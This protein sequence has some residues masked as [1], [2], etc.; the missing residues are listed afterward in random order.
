MYSVVFDSLRHHGLYHQVL[1]SKKFSRQEYWNR[2]PFPIPG[3]LHDPEI[4]PA[5]LATPVLAGGSF[6]TD[7]PGKPWYILKPAQKLALLI[8][9]DVPVLGN[10]LMPGTTLGPSTRISSFNTHSTP[11]FNRVYCSVFTRMKLGLEVDKRLAKITQ[12]GNYRG[13]I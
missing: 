1:L 8:Q 11:L 2:L 10:Q 3:D 7:T 6:T 4:E 9:G 5:S 13:R 12:L